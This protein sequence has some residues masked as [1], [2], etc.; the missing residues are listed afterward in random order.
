MGMTGQLHCHCHCPSNR[1]GL[2]LSSPTY[3]S[4]GKDFAGVIMLRILRC[5]TI[6]VPRWALMLSHV[7]FSEDAEGEQRQ[8]GPVTTEAEAGGTRPRAKDTGPGSWERQE[9]HPPRASCGMR[10]C[11]TDLRLGARAGG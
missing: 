5:E 11:F 10:P 1:E 2:M 3:S 9:G 4:P 7:S 6:W 8:R